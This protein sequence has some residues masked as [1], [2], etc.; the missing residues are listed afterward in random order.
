MNFEELLKVAKDASLD[1]GYAILDVYGT[2]D[3]GVETKSDNSP[4]TIADKK[5]HDIILKYLQK[6]G[7]PVLSEEGNKI[8]FHE[9]KTWE[10]FWMVDPLDGTKEFIKRN[11]EFTVNIALI[12]NKKPIMGVIYVPT[13]EKL[14]YGIQGFG[15]Y[16]EENKNKVQLPF[17]KNDTDT[18]KIVASRNYLNKETK[19]F[20]QT[21]PKHELLS[22]GSS[23]KFM[24]IAEGNADV[25]PR[26]APTSEWDTAAA[27]AIVEIVG[28]KVVDFETKE[29]LVY[30]KENLLNPF[31]LVFG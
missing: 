14:Y 28:G 12:K 22:M 4:L 5:S 21:Y 11:G 20:I 23:L 26:L 16:L 2:K 30:N 1:A 9:R 31:F 13:F 19:D 25:Y 29:P 24:L 7:I 17:T 6:T 18:V 8:P 27:Q 3:Y 15:A 10:Y